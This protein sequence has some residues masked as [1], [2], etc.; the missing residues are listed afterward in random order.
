MSPFA[1]LQL[2][3]AFSLYLSTVLRVLQ[4]P[5]A[6]TSTNYSKSISNNSNGDGDSDRGTKS[7]RKKPYRQKMSLQAGIVLAIQLLVVVLYMVKMAP[8][9]V[10]VDVGVLM[11]ASLVNL[12]M[13]IGEDG[14]AE[15]KCLNQHCCRL[16]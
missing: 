3:A 1:T 10:S 2:A 13:V 7:K 6:I 11:T 14:D 16:C 12:Y 15:G 8:P 9:L 5:I 4:R